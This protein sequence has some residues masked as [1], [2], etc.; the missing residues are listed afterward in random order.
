VDAILCAK[1]GVEVDLGFVDE[2]EIGADDDGC[3]DVAAVSAKLGTVLCHG[4]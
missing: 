1:V 4:T 2:F 3:F